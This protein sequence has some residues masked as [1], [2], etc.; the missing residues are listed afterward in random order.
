MRSLRNWFEKAFPQDEGRQHPR[1]ERR[2]VEGL[3]AIHWTG[4]S[5]GLDIVKNISA[6]GM[7]LVTRERWPEG[8]V[9]PIRLVYPE[10]KDDKPEKP[11]HYID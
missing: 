10:L 7:Y 4:S 9:N 6:T 8:Q 1:A 3:E 11:V 5:P 2:S